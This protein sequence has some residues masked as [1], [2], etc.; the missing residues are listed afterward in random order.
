MQYINA[1]MHNKQEVINS[2][3]ATRTGGGSLSA[4]RK[5]NTQ[6]R[7]IFDGE[8]QKFLISGGSKAG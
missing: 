1:S 2:R 8:R 7:G 6:G 4:M 5:G 3:F